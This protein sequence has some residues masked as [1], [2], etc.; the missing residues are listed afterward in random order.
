MD[1][2]YVVI[3]VTAL[4]A[5]VA[6]FL[7]SFR[8]VTKPVADRNEEIFNKRAILSAVG[9]Y[10]GE[11]VQVKD[12]K[13]DQVLDIFEKQ[14]QQLVLNTQGTEIDGV[15]AE[16]I[17]MA[18]EKKKADSEKRLPLFI[19]SQGGEKFY[20]LSVRGVG[21]WDEIWGNIAL[22]SDINT[23]AGA[24][25]DHAGE[26]PGLGAEIKDNASFPRSFKGKQ[27]FDNGEYVS[28]NV[29]KGGAIDKDHEVDG[30]TGATVTSDGVTDMLYSGI[31]NYLPYL[32]SLRR[33]GMLLK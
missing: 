3:F 30:I 16:D 6:V 33:Q 28:V 2:R 4:T 8:Q 20:I 24:S 14:M 29:R 17:D 31:E 10:L 11:G 25:F 26:T 22:K 21:L 1:T 27:I 15:K 32:N 13:D 5:G 12:L 23:I 7:T 19:F 18:K 9:D